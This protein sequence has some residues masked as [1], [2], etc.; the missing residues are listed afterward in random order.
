MSRMSKQQIKLHKQAEE[1]LKKDVLTFDDK[2]FVIDNWNEGYEF[3]NARFGAFFTPQG[4]AR[5]F[6]IEVSGPKV[7]DLCAGI[8]TLAFAYV[9]FRHHYNPEKIKITCVEMN[10]RYVEIGKKILPEAEWIC[11]DLFE[12]WQTLDRNY[13]TA[14]SNPPFGKTVGKDC[15]DPRYKG[16]EFEFKVIDIASY[17]AS[18]GVFIVPQ[19]SAGFRFSGVQC[20]DRNESPK[21]KKFAE[22]TGIRLEVGCGVDCNFHKD[23]WKEVNIVVEIATTEFLK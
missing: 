7:I 11:A 6:N 10:P 5:D 15:V 8:G 2:L 20:Y 17:L 21:Y 12:V 16:S 3:D 19:M 9:H 13:D 18:F 1:L 4:L 22:Q 14:I 23:D